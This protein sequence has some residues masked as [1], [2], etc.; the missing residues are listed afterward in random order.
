MSI[1]NTLLLIETEATLRTLLIELLEAAQEA[2]ATGC[3]IDTVLLD[4][5][6][7]II[8]KAGSAIEDLNADFATT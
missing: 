7:L 1:E 3:D 5:S 4:E 6:A 8:V 2:R